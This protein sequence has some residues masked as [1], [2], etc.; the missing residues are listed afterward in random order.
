MTLDF[1]KNIPIYLRDRILLPTILPLF[2]CSSEFCF[3]ITLILLACGDTES[4]P[5][6]R[7]HDSY[8]NF[9]VCH[10]NL[11]S[12]TEHNVGKI[13]LLEAYNTINKFDVIC[14]SESY[15]DSP[16]NIKGYNLYRANHPT[17]LKEVVY[18]C[19]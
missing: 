4:N 1:L 19:I 6:P 8:Y 12:V 17:M 3:F 9:L 10:W 11:N 14:L 15:L 13:K 7:R 18:V 16:L 5:G 2:S